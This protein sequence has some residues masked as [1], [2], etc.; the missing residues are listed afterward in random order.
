MSIFNIDDEV[1]DFVTRAKKSLD[2]FDEAV[3]A[4]KRTAHQAEGSLERVNK[5]IDAIQKID[6]PPATGPAGPAVGPNT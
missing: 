6:N 3:K 1:K 2:E 4:I 5:I